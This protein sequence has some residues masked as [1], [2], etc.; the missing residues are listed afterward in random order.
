MGTTD[1]LHPTSMD[2]LLFD[3]GDARST[4]EANALPKDECYSRVVQYRI[5]ERNKTVEQIFSYGKEEW[6]A[7]FSA[8]HSGSSYMSDENALFYRVHRLPLY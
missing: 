3:N 6:L 8:I 1:W 4:S 7:L 5:N 2:I